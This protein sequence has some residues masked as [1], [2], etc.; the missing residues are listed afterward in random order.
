MSEP[1]ESRNVGY[2]EWLYYA[3]SGPLANA[4]VVGKQQA[5]AFALASYGDT[6]TGENIRPGRETLA[7]GADAS[8]RTVSTTMQ[9]LQ[10]AGFL[11]LVKEHGPNRPTVYRLCVPADLNGKAVESVESAPVERPPAPALSADEAARVAAFDAAPD[12]YADN[13]QDDQD[14]A[15]AAPVVDVWTSA[16]QAN[17]AASDPAPVEPPAVEHVDLSG[18]PDFGEDDADDNAAAEYEDDEP[19]PEPE[20]GRFAARARRQSEQRHA[21]ELREEDAAAQRHRPR[22]R[23]S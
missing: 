9:A 13:E 1:V 14:D 19:E 2:F 5:I 8:E 22:Y 12:P 10:A 16:E 11:A 21:A 17:T 3:R 20:L 15:P 7:K 6:H 18:V 23:N 4:G